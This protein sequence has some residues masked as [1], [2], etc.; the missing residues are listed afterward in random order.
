MDFIL[1]CVKDFCLWVLILAAVGGCA[2]G[3]VVLY[4][5][6]HALPVVQEV[7]PISLVSVGVNSL[8]M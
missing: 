7:G 3:G 5:I 1:K 6:Y 8:Y 4:D 2:L